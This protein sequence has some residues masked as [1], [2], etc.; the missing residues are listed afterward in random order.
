MNKM[1]IY[2]EGKTEALFVKKLI[3][4]IAG[5]NVVIDY[6]EKRGGGRA[7]AVVTLS[8]ITVTKNTGQA[9]YIL[10]VDCGGEYAVKSRIKDDQASLTQADY[11]KILGIRD[12]R[13]NFSLAD[14]PRLEANLPVGIDP[15]LAPVEFILAIM[16]I[17]AWFLAE[18][19]HFSR[20]DIAITVD[21]IK[22]ALNFDPRN[23]DMQQRPVPSDDLRNCYAIGKKRYGKSEAQ[24]QKTLDVLDYALIYLELPSKFK[25]LKKLID[26]IEAFL[27]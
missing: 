27:A 17:E 10:L 15:L 20:I 9:Y 12:V 14:V 18:T 5:E 25:Y 4:E 24:V 16:E 8:T 23:D 1:A 19:T 3:E 7:G 2:V 11:S 26:S 13:P 22:A 21:A 6:K